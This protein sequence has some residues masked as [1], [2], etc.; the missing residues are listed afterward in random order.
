[1]VKIYKEV[2]PRFKSSIFFQILKDRKI[3]LKTNFKDLSRGQKMQFL[4][5]L[6]LASRPKILF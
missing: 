3:S 6:A 1:M 4:L 5:M 2:F